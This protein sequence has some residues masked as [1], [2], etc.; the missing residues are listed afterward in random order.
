MIAFSHGNDHLATF[1]EL[2]DERLRDI[3]GRAGDDDAIEGGMF[4]PALIAVAIFDV[5]ICI[6]EF[7]ESAGGLFGEWRDDFDGV[8]IA[9]DFGEYGGLVAA[10]G[11]DFKDFIIGLWIESFGHVG[12]DERWRDGLLVTDG[13]SGIF[14]GLGFFGAADEFVSVDFAHGGEDAGVGDAF[15]FERSADHDFALEFPFLLGGRVWSECIEKEDGD[16]GCEC[17]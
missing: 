6:S 15:G 3:F 7:C 1:G 2:I 9:D 17:G 5:D 13:E 14:V 10:S 8:D 11:A 4:G 16:A 12:D